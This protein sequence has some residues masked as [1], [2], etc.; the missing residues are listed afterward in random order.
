MNKNNKK[1]NKL[2]IKPTLKVINSQNSNLMTCGKLKLNH[3][4]MKSSL[5]LF[6]FRSTSLKIKLFRK[7][8]CN[9][10]SVLKLLFNH[11]NIT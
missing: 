11:S 9:N 5:K 4:Q 7:S 3:K 1:Y 6:F 2:R 10:F 8:N